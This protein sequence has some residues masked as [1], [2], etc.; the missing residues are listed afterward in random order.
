MQYLVA[1]EHES[2]LVDL[3]SELET[4]RESLGITDIQL[5]LTSLEEVFLT[6]AKKVSWGEADGQAYNRW[7]HPQ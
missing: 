1:R 7:Q 4:R 3:L 5:C 2:L 6:I